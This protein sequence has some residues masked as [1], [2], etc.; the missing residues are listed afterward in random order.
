MKQILITFLL[1]LTLTINSTAQ[2]AMCRTTLENNISQGNPGIAAGINFGVTNFTRTA[3][4][5]DS[6]PLSSGGLGFDPLRKA[7][8]FSITPT[9][10]TT[11][12]PY[13]FFSLVPSFEYRS[14][15]YT[16]HSTVPNLTRGYLLF[17][18]DFT[19]QLEKIFDTSNPAIP[20]VKHLIRPI[21]TFNWIPSFFEYPTEHPFLQQIN[22]A[23]KNGASGYNF[24]SYDIVPI[25]TSRS[26][27]DYLLPLGKSLSYGFTSQLIRRVGPLTAQSGSYQR[28]VELRAAQTLNFLEFKNPPG[29]RQP[30][31]KFDSSLALSFDKWS[32]SANYVYFPYGNISE[33]E[34]R[35]TISMGF[36]YVLER[37]THQD[38]LAFDRSLSLSY[39]YA[40]R[41]NNLTAS[42]SYSLS[43]YI[44]PSI[45]ISYMFLKPGHLQS[46]NLGLKFQSPARCWKLELGLASAVCDKV[47]PDDTGYCQTFSPDLTLNLTGSG[48]GGISQVTS[49]VIQQ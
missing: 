48:Y 46:I 18:T 31:S 45:G 32:A 6:D 4:D 37:A 8:R 2:C 41:T 13:D 30:F 10:Y 23:N 29:D 22:N 40:N 3:G 38:I 24:D 44:L 25:N 27:N 1:T 16:F 42:L 36:N 15:F 7:T 9:L 5:F 12:R 34:S 19:S 43:D 11:L 49:T 33:K 47:R 26:Y 17:K 20:K 39:A 28:I 35:N 21:L 14:F